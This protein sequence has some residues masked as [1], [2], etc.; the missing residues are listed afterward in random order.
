MAE[1]CAGVNV[2]DFCFVN[3][4]T[5]NMSSRESINALNFEHLLVFI[6]AGLS[7]MVERDSELADGTMQRLTGL[8]LV[9]R[10]GLHQ[11][12]D[13]DAPLF[14]ACHHLLPL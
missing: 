8:L 9:S 4:S 14:K 13:Q 6:K 5:V 7:T 1:N 12:L 2:P 11:H 10:R 3:M